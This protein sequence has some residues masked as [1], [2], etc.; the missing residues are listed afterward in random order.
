MKQNEMVCELGS[1]LL[2]RRFV[3]LKYG[4]EPRIASDTR[5]A[6]HEQTHRTPVFFQGQ[7]HKV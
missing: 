3:F 6:I 5:P 7:I 2:V 4:F 1:T